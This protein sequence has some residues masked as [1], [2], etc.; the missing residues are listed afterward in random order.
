MPFYGVTSRQIVEGLQQALIDLKVPHPLHLHCNNLGVPG[1]VETAVATIDAARGMPLHLAHMQFYGYGS[2]GE[3]HFSSAAATL[4]AKVNATPN[5]TVDIGQVMFGQTVTISADTL[6]QFSATGSAKPKKSV[7]NDGDANG[8]GIVPYVYREGDFINAIQWACGLELFL[9]I[10][11]PYRIFFTTDHP[12]GAPFT[13]YPDLFALLMS[14][15]RRAEALSRIPQE[16]ARLDDAALADAR[17]QLQ[18]NRR[19]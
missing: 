4:A 8:F 13:T 2:E 6:R 17:I 16:R 9:L 15:E 18:R 3:H 7:I 14:R 12:N 11:D 5:V 10:N 1:N 19:R